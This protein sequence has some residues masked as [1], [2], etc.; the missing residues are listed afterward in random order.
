MA[1]RGTEMRNKLKSVLIGLAVLAAPVGASIAV[2]P[3]ASAACFHVAHYMAN[4]TPGQNS[5]A[6]R[7]YSYSTWNYLHTVPGWHFYVYYTNWG[8]C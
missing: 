2:A 7:E 3:P 8:S 6:W 1:M 5:D 4:P